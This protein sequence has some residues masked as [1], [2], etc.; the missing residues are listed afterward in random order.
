MARM[1]SMER[2]FQFNIRNAFWATALAAV[3]CALFAAHGRVFNSLNSEYSHFILTSYYAAIVGLPAVV[4]GTILG[5]L[6][7]GAICGLASAL[8]TFAMQ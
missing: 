3:W 1:G 6:A 7:V 8:A 5:R 2:R 4:V